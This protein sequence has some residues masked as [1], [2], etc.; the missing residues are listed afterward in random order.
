M[1][2]QSYLTFASCKCQLRYQHEPCAHGPASPSCRGRRTVL[3]P[4]RNPI[5]Y[6]HA[7]IQ[8]Q[9][10]RARERDQKYQERRKQRQL[11]SG[12]ASA[13]V[14]GG[15]SLTLFS[16][17]S[18]AWKREMQVMLASAGRRESWWNGW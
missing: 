6:Q 1:C 15:T 9:Q 4:A 18:D 12:A 13:R 17:G 10:Q 11:N 7:F 2:R 16:V 8:H 14:V 5:C 3:V